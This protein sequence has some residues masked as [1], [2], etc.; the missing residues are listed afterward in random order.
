MRNEA[1]KLSMT[2]DVLLGQSAD[3]FDVDFNMYLHNGKIRRQLTDF[4]LSTHC[5]KRVRIRSFFGLYFPAFGMNTDRK[6][7]KYGHFSHSESSFSLPPENMK[8]SEVF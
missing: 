2:F 5:V 7:S 1:T 8:E 3:A 4:R 6:N